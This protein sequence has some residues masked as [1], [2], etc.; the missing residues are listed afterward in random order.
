VYRTHSRF[1]GNKAENCRREVNIVWQLL[2]RRNSN[3]L[4]TSINSSFATTYT[5]RQ[6]WRIPGTS[7][8]L[9]AALIH[10]TRPALARQPRASG[11]P[12][13]DV[14]STGVLVSSIAT[15][16]E[17]RARLLMVPQVAISPLAEAGARLGRPPTFMART[18]ALH[19]IAVRGE[20]K[21]HEP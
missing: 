20:P 2:Q 6:H 16:A 9:P 4:A 21:H 5:T 18:G 13:Q 7:R 19:S 17:R 1:S 8:K 15:A 10:P 12:A 11:R 3:C 14:R